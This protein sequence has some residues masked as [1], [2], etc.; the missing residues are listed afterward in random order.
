MKKYILPTAGVVTTAIVYERYRMAIYKQV[1][2]NDLSKV[3]RPKVVVIGGGII[4]SMTAF[5]LNKNFDVTLVDK[6]KK[7]PFSGSSF[8]Q[9][10]VI[11]PYC[12]V[13]T[14]WTTYSLIMMF[15]DCIFHWKKNRFSI[16]FWDFVKNGK[17]L[18]LAKFWYYHIVAKQHNEIKESRDFGHKLCMVGYDLIEDLLNQID[19]GNIPRNLEQ[20][21]YIF[22]KEGEAQST[23]NY[24]K[25]LGTADNFT[26]I[27]TNT[28]Y[29]NLLTEAEKKYFDKYNEVLI[30]KV[31]LS[32]RR[33]VLANSLK[34]LTNNRSNFTKI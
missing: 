17:F 18:H 24:Y 34:Y 10:G 23:Y 26:I 29:Q 25:K 19:E 11:D 20:D 2:A 27:N 12:S 8:Y 31:H 16:D 9:S 14:P 13:V 1:P 7:D 32:N 21:Q 15:Y 4:G 33:L 30:T 28:K 22:F 5:Y 6:N 3:K